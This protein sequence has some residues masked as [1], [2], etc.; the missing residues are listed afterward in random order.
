MANP[1]RMGFRNS[2]EVAEENT[3]EIVRH[4][5][6]NLAIGPNC[7][8]RCEGCYNNFG[9]SFSNGGLVTAEEITNFAADV[10]ARDI[11]G[12]TLS[13]GDP[14]FHPEIGDILGG[15]HDLDYRIKVDTVGTALLED[16]RIVY[17]GR[18][19]V[20]RVDIEEVKH[21]LESVTLPLDGVDQG[22]IE[23][24]RRG[25]KNIFEETKVIAHILAEAGVDFGFNTVVNARNKH[26]V[27][28]I[29]RLAL[30]LGAF[31]WHVFE[32][33][34]NGPNPSR[35]KDILRISN[36]EFDAAV[37]GLDQMPMEGMRL[38]L[39]TRDSRVGVGA[40]FFVNDAGEAWS[41]SEEG[42]QTKFGHI[43]RE[44]EKEMEAYDNHLAAFREKFP[45]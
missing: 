9:E 11:D 35:Q 31:E 27:K 37:E 26:Q 16:S 8:V 2:S 1:E 28:D 5:R 43:T 40:Y 10:R 6:L 15:L 25:R 3:Q 19:A 30:S 45:A 24:F 44:R 14:L 41:P 18:G 39:R 7:S 21:T 33:D 20:P 23:N 36:E 4:P 38:D 17:K 12:V 29:G 32:Y 13:G 42:G 34:P 22:T